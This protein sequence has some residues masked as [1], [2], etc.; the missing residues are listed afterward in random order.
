MSQAHANGASPQPEPF[1]QT[2]V[3]T[4]EEQ[5]E[6]NSA[7]EPRSHLDMWATTLVVAQDMADVLNDGVE[8]EVEM[9][10]EALDQTFKWNERR[11][12]KIENARNELMR[13]NRQV[14]A[15]RDTLEKMK[16]SSTMRETQAEIY[17]LEQASYEEAREIKNLDASV[18]SIKAQLAKL[19]TESEELEQYEP[20]RS[21]DFV[22]GASLLKT[23]L[24][25]ELGFVQVQ[26]DP[27]STTEPTVDKFFLRCDCNPEASRVISKPETNREGF[28]LANEIWDLIT[29]KQTN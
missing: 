10:Y 26:R 11:R 8:E 23:K 22:I 29:E 6:Q 9:T 28:E 13:V 17:S 19:Q 12:E 27:D 25:H 18:A 7:E 16:A 20:S 1:Y 5:Q 21:P 14:E 24:Y 2:T 15:K 3:E 4:N